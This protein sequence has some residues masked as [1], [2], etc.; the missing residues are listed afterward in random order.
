MKTN[1]KLKHELLEGFFK[2]GGS[3]KN[4]DRIVSFENRLKNYIKD[5]DKNDKQVLNALTLLS[6]YKMDDN[7][8]SLFEIS[9]DLVSSIVERLLN[10]DTYKWDFYDILFSQGAIFWAKTSEIAIKLARKALS[11]IRSHKEYER[12]YT[13]ELN[14]SSNVMNRLLRADFIEI[15]HYEEEELHEKVKA[16]F[17]EHLDFVL[18]ICRSRGDE[19]RKYELMALIRKGL[20]DRDSQAIVENLSLLREEDKELHR[21]MKDSVI[22]YSTYIGFDMSGEQFDNLCGANIRYY[23]EKLGMSKETLAESINMSVSH[24]TNFENGN[25]PMKFHTAMAIARTFGITTDDLYYGPNKKNG[26]DTKEEAEL[27]LLV[28]EARG[29]KNWL[30]DLRIIAKSMLKRK[31]EV[32]KQRPLINLPPE[33]SEG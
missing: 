7:D 26:F 16:S 13:I 19:L 33:E 1:D 30:G 18:A 9:C 8:Y 10:K 17:N 5:I 21:A 28:A 11:A 15:N 6:V 20:L 32:E 4:T 27:A 23:R 2:I 25:K 24:L 22:S 12:Y 14:I 3:Y 29:L 31:R